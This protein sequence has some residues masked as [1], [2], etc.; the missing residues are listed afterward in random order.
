M[1]VVRFSKLTGTLHRQV[2]LFREFIKNPAEIGT[3]T[4]S[5]R[6]LSRKMIEKV[7]FDRS[8][9][10]VEVGP[11]TGAIT[12]EIVK[13]IRTHSDYLL[14]E[15]SAR[16]ADF[17]QSQ[18]S[19]VDIA[20]TSAEHIRAELDRRNLDK[21][22]VIIS[23]LPWVNMPE[24]LQSSLLNA[25]YEVLADDGM[26]CT[27]NYMF[28]YPFRRAKNFRRLARQKFSHISVEN[29]SLL[30]IPPALVINMKK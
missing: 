16:M 6:F 14:I 24:E 28:A 11:G 29:Y 23:G 10:I 21:C 22:D 15:S 13:N 2:Y 27:Y 26:I 17:I 19:H 18:I 30:N 1:D 20:V 25:F 9:V 3:I 12:R 8:N 7:D 5:S 4:Y